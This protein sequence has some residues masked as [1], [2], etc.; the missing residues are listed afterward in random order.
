M[1]TIKTSMIIV[2]LLILSI[3]TVYSSEDGVVVGS[4]GNV[5]I[6]TATPEAKLDVKGDINGVPTIFEVYPNAHDQS[7]ATGYILVKHDTINLNTNPGAFTLSPDHSIT[8]NKSGYYR[9]SQRAL[10][11]KSE[12]GYAHTRL[13]V[14]NAH[15]SWLSRSKAVRSIVGWVEPHGEKILFLQAGSILKHEL[16][17]ESAT[18]YVYYIGDINDICTYMQIERLN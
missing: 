10:V 9:I 4:G 1:R 7:G 14:N 16:W 13:L 6:G 2:L 18:T 5:G 15:N 3:T 17:I 8:V 11:N 12:V